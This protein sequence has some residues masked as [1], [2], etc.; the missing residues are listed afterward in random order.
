MQPTL[1]G[2]ISSLRQLDECRNVDEFAERSLDLLWDLIPCHALSFNE[3]DH[4]HRRF[5]LFRSRGVSAEDE[6][7]DEEF[8]SYADD[9]PICW[10][11]PPGGAGVIRTR[12]VISRRALDSSR[13]YSE[14]L[15]PFGCEHEMKVAFESPPWVSRAFIFTRSDSAF[16]DRELERARLVAPHLSAAYRRLRAGKALT[17][18]EG[19]VLE[20]VARGL[21]NRE[22]AT[23][24]D[25][26]PGTV[27]AHLEH[28]F[29]KL[30]V[31]TR[32]AA[33]AATR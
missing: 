22:I 29:S 20:L 7:S 13:I 17:E 12:D 6:G 8:W 2:I 9:L 31:R 16:T 1:D 24:L 10:G 23:A 4:A 25:I 3:L 26:S 11:L 5:D 28:V 33:V 14:V 15:R 27:R 19:E 32:T 21:A 18:R 30:G